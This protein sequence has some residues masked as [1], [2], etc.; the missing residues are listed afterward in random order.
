MQVDWDSGLLQADLPAQVASQAHN[1]HHPKKR[2]KTQSS[3]Q[4]ASRSAKTQVTTSP[5]LSDQWLQCRDA[6]IR[7]VKALSPRQETDADA[8]DAHLFKTVPEQIQALL[9]MLVA[10]KKSNGTGL[11]CAL[12]AVVGQW[13]Q[14][15]LQEHAASAAAT[16]ITDMNIGMLAD[17][18]HS[19]G[20]GCLAV[21]PCSQQPF[22]SYDPNLQYCF[23]C[24]RHG[25]QCSDQLCPLCSCG[26]ALACMRLADVVLCIVFSS[27]AT[28]GCA[29]HC[30]NAH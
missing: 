16:H 5:P 12:A 9:N 29:Q 6:I 21:A 4:H 15:V 23:V 30:D 19:P 17:K 25:R 3:Q 18:L 10:A 7:V 11:V 1:P 24:M 14:Y 8:G 26:S 2:R 22:W 20:K 27:M 28:D 13:A